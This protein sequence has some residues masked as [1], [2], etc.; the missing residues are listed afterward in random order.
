MKIVCRL[1]TFLSVELV[2]RFKANCAPIGLGYTWR[3]PSVEVFLRDLSP[4]L[5]KFQRNPWKI[6]RSGIEP[7]PSRQPVFWAEPLG[8]WWDVLSVELFCANV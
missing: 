4:Y 3:E 8:H 2:Y 1:S 6:T 5:L 7:V